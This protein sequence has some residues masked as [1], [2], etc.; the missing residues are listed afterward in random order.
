MS[1]GSL[2]VNSAASRARERTSSVRYGQLPI[3]SRAV[4]SSGR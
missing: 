4:M 2:T 3:G 1:S